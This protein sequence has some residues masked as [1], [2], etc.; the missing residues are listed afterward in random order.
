MPLTG[1]YGKCVYVVIY[2][3]YAPY[4]HVRKICSSCHVS[5]NMLHRSTL[6]LEMPTSVY[7]VLSYNV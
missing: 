3:K 1:I 6:L 5:I 2:E 4:G 7:P